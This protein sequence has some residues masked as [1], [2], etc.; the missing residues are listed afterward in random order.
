MIALLTFFTSDTNPLIDPAMEGASSVQ[1]PTH[2]FH[3]N[4]FSSKY[5]HKVSKNILTTRSFFK[6]LTT[7]KLLRY[8]SIIDKPDKSLFYLNINLINLNNYHSIGDFSSFF[9]MYPY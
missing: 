5:L 6:F 9:Q 8:L 3:D 7:E 2:S 1:T 4:P